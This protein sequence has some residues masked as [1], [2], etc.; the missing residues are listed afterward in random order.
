M[1]RSL[2][3]NRDNVILTGTGMENVDPNS[4][5]V[6]SAVGNNSIY[7]AYNNAIEYRFFETTNVE[8]FNNLTNNSKKLSSSN[9]SKQLYFSHRVLVC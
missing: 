2:S 6:L 9:H 7:I 5:I 4:E 8:I 1:I 3:G